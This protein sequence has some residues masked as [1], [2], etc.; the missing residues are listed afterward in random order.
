MEPVPEGEEG[1]QYSLAIPLNTI[2]DDLD[3][4]MDL[5]S[6]VAG[7]ES[8]GS[9]DINGHADVVAD[10][11]EE[12]ED[13]A[14]EDQQD[15][16][17]GGNRLYLVGQHLSLLAQE[18]YMFSTRNMQSGIICWSV[19]F[20]HLARRLRHLELER[21]IEARFGGI[22]VRIVRVL[23]AKGKLDEKR[24][25]EIS[26]MA[27]KDLRQVLAQMEA[28][29]FIDL[30]EVPRDAQRQPAR[31]IYLWFYDPDR[32]ASMVIEDTYKSMARC[33]QRVAV[34][35]HK[36][37]YFLEKTERTD[38]KGNEERFLSSGELKTLQQWRDTEAM[39]FGEVSR[40]DD[41]IAIL[42]DY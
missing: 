2:L 13:A 34:E 42:R 1:E 17:A 20:R 16:N 21:L 41:I 27:T 29:G 3:P 12:D 4:S 39:L 26:L 18:P 40:L 22:A 14:Q 5:V 36:L 15:T 37:K 23:A 28:A 32:V 24:L 38:V 7:L 8:G 35:R 30:Q 19:E 9:M 25:Q 6:A 11:D 10:L 33:L 31:T